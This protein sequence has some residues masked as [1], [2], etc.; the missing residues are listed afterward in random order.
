MMQVFMKRNGGGNMSSKG[1]QLTE[2][3]ISPEAAASMR[4][5]DLSLV[6]EIVRERMYT[7]GE[8]IPI[9]NLFGIDIIENEDLGIGQP[10]VSIIYRSVYTW[11]EYFT[12]HIEVKQ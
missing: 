6:P 3:Y 4:S 7:K 11:V 5:W 2:L 12:L 10:L 1:F 8:G 9:A